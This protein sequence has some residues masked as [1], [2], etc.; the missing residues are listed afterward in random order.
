MKTYPLASFVAILM[1][2][3]AGAAPTAQGQAPA[4]PQP[5]AADKAD[6]MKGCQDHHAAVTVR[7]DRLARTL[8]EARAAG[9]ITSAHTAIETAQS[10]LAEIRAAVG[11]C[12]AKMGGMHGAPAA[13]TPPAEHKH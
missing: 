13:S 2:A 7:L 5:A 6:M 3:S 9:D 12:S 11:K 8:D 1:L 4:T 10:N